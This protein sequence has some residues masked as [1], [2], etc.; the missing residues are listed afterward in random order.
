MAEDTAPQGP[1]I[2]IDSDWKQQAQAEKERLAAE[3][4]SKSKSADAG[5]AGAAGAPPQVG[6]PEGLPPA[7]FEEVLATF[8]TQVFM[9]LGD[10]PN[11]ATG[12]PEI[13]LPIAKHYIDLLSLL[14]AKTRGN[15]T[16]EE[17]KYFDQLLYEARMRYVQVAGGGVRP[18]RSRPSPP[19]GER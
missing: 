5:A 7:S 3:V 2:Q 10:I 14:E 12:R 15:L 16:A 11:P 1:K 4:E 17:K 13:G 19:K 6:G 8:A 18:A 9:C